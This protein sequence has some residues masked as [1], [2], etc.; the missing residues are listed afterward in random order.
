MTR[1]ALASSLVVLVL[2][3]LAPPAAAAWTWPLRGEVI[4]P[5]RNGDDPYAAGQH[6]GIDIAGPVGAPVVAA[7]AGEVRFV[8]VAGSSGLTVSV[9]TADGRLDT[10]YLHLSAATVTAGEHVA[11]GQRLG[12]VGISGQR[13]AVASHLH[14]GVRDAG[15]QRY[16]DPLGLLPPLATVPE[17]R[18]QAPAPVT[19]PGPSATQPG[20]MRLPMTAPRRVPVA[21]PRPVPSAR[22]KR[23]PAADRKHLPL[24]DPRRT[25]AGRP[26]PAGKRLL[27]PRTRSGTVSGAPDPRPAAMSQRPAGLHARGYGDVPSRP[28]ASVGTGRSPASAGTVSLH[29]RG[30]ADA[31]RSAPDRHVV[32]SNTPAPGPGHASAGPDAGWALACLG[33]LGAA[34]LVGTS[35]GGRTAA[36]GGKTALRRLLTPLTGRL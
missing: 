18:P 15:T 17:T 23:V 3:A 5:Y 25:P 20:V 11:A 7:V 13:S 14:F 4:T 31:A 8:G 32:G 22:P 35:G 29:A 28:A 12:A 1:S 24:T 10:S 21:P 34:A 26:A 30:D 33:L 9:R 6:R 2:L 19:V 16:Y 36:R 27:V